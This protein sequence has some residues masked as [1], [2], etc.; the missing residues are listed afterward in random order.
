MK[1]HAIG[2]AKEEFAMITNIC[3]AANIF[4]KI[5]CEWFAT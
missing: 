2:F 5:K 3:H 1:S 4:L